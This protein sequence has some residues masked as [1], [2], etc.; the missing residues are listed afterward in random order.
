MLI[1]IYTLF[2][3]LYSN[4]EACDIASVLKSSGASSSTI[5][6]PGVGVE[7]D[8]IFIAVAT[9]SSFKNCKVS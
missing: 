2:T 3:V 5:R 1:K 7:V 9:F 6:P 4:L 8:N